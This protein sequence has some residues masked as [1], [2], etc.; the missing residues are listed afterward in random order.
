MQSNMNLSIILSR[1]HRIDARYIV[2][3]KW[4]INVPGGCMLHLGAGAAL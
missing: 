2:Q 4:K 3:G 1:V